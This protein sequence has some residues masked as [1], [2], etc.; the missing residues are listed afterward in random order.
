MQFGAAILTIVLVLMTGPI[1]L[2]VSDGQ[3][4]A[5]E[6]VRIVEGSRIVLSH[7]NSIYDQRVDEVLELRGGMMKLVEVKTPSQGVKEYYLPIGE[8]GDHRWRELYLQ[9]S[10]DRNFVL[11]VE[12][13]RVAALEKNR[14]V[15]LR[16]R[17]E[18]ITDGP[19]QGG[20][21]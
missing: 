7:F 5:L 9:N 12:G 4:R 11:S 6:K 16:L 19:D 17:V 1:F 13:K 20:K 8:V 18:Q 14:N 15:R 10:E 2:V 21:R 3:G